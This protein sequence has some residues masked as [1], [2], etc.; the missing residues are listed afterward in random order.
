LFLTEPL[1]LGPCGG[2]RD[3]RGHKLSEFPEAIQCVRR[4][5][6]TIIA[7]RHYQ[8]TPDTAAD[9]DGN[10]GP[11]GDAEIPEDRRSDA[12]DRGVIVDSARLARP[13]HR[14][15]QAGV[16]SRERQPAAGVAG[17]FAGA[18]DDCRDAGSLVAVEPDQRDMKKPR[19][20]RRD[21]GEDF[22]R[23][24]AFGD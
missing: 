18:G 14:R 11:R 13:L 3:G 6:R 10:A 4:Q 7:G 1:D 16:V 5:W 19:R 24:Y 9:D 12:V 23:R 22:G 20:L 17:E 15:H 2:V 8:R 21:S